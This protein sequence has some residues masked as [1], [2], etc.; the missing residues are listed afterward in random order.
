M[1]TGHK[2]ESGDT[3]SGRKTLWRRGYH[4]Q[5]CKELTLDVFITAPESQAHLMGRHTW[6]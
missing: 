5:I 6:I 4:L 1:A 2:E 3:Y